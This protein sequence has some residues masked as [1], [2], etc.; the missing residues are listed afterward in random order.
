MINIACGANAAYLPY[1]AT[2]L[3]SLLSQPRSESLTVHF[4]H[5]DA[6]PETERVRLG[7]MVESLGGIW[8]EHRITSE[9]L[10]PFPHNWRFGR[11]AW[12]RVLLPELLGD[13]SRV[14][15]LD[16][17]TVVLRPIEPLWAT[18]LKGQVA[19]VV[20]NPMYP[21]LDPGFMRKLGLKSPDEYFNS[22]VLLLDL[23]RWR[24]ENLSRQLLDFVAIHGADQQWPDQNA[25]NVVLYGRCI[26]LEP[27]WNAQNVYFDLQPQQLP[28]PRDQAERIRTTPAIVHF[29]APYKPL[30]YLCKHPFRMNHLQHL[31]QT[32]WADAPIKGKTLAARLLRLLPQ[33]A[34]WIFLLVKVPSWRRRLRRV[35]MP[36]S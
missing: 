12:Y 33:P 17:D 15:Y 14:L 11:E 10:Q 22:G 4:M 7:A 8:R 16:A 25:L 35:L 27:I 2:M 34:M 23:D 31:A 36:S 24:A 30:D 20:M 1:V 28:I 13:V 6:L 21:F 32:P 9:Q 18:D 29:I 5:E 3:H 19:G 26:L